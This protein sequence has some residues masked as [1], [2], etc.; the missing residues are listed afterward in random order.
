MKN[1]EQE[2]FVP[3]NFK[4]E[5]IE[6]S[7]AEAGVSKKK[8]KNT[9]ITPGVI[10]SRIADKKSEAA[11]IDVPE[12]RSCLRCGHG[13]KAGAKFC[14]ECGS[15][16]SAPP[17]FKKIA[18]KE[19]PNFSDK[20]RAVKFEYF[21]KITDEYAEKYPETIANMRKLAEEAGFENFFITDIGYKNLSDT[22]QQTDIHMNPGYGKKAVFFPSAYLD[23]HILFEK[24]D[25]E[26]TDKGLKIVLLHEKEH[27]EDAAKKANQAGD[28]IETEEDY[29]EYIS[30]LAKEKNIPTAEARRRMR[31]AA[32]ARGMLT[33]SQTN[34]QVIAKNPEEF[35]DKKDIAEKIALGEAYTD[36]VSQGAEG[37]RK[38]ISSEDEYY[39]RSGRHYSYGYLS[40][41]KDIL[42]D[43]IT[44]QKKLEEKLIRDYD[45]KYG[46]KEADVK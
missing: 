3:D 37:L 16:L 13:A 18:R 30:D 7:R 29:D 39:E 21:K 44:E 1:I 5:I 6:N 17:D 9:F 25:K 22:V 41:G 4:E 20:E 10:E 42:F 32:Q 19:I 24:M 34:L 40:L 2:N 28:Q 12:S 36:A 26:F 23:N 27:A 33:E 15:D 43:T 11:E 38:K 46:K 14:T 35:K 45:E 8:Y 31:V